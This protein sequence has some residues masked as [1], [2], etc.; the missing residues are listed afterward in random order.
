MV[1]V[2]ATLSYPPLEGKGR[3]EVAGWGD[4]L[5]IMQG[6]SNQAA[7]TDHLELIIT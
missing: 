5:T 7:A 3:H 1:W 4:S 6:A 2:E